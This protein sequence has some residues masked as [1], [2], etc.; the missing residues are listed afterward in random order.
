M[1]STNIVRV[2]STNYSGEE[3]TETDNPSFKTDIFEIDPSDDLDWSAT[4]IDAS[5]FGVKLI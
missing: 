3:H 1:K 2:S 5:E 4:K